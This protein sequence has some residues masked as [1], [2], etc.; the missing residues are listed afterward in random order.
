MVAPFDN[1]SGDP[2][3]DYFVDGMRDAL[4][5]ELTKVA[6]LTVITGVAERIPAGE[7]PDA[8]I[9]A[10]SVL[11]IG[12]RVRINARL[13]EGSTNR[14]VWAESYDGDLRD[15][16]ALHGRVA[17]AITQ[18]VEAELTPQEETRLATAPP[19]DPEAYNLYLR[20][21]FHW[22]KRTAAGL[23]RAVRYF[24]QAIDVDP[25][26]ALAYAGLADAYVLFPLYRVPGVSRGE[27]YQLAEQSAREALARDSTLG[28]AR[29]ALAAVLFQAHRDWSR[30]ALEFQRALALSPGY[31]TLHQWYSEYLRAAGRVEES[32]AEARRAYRL[33]PLEPVISTSLASGLWVA[34]R[35]DEAIAEARRTL[36]ELDPSYADAYNV[37]ALCYLALSRFD[38]LATTALQAGYP[39]SLVTPVTQALTGAGSREGAV[40]AITMH[41]SLLDPFQAAVL[42]SAV[43]EK[44]LALESLERAEQEGNVN[45]LIYLKSAPAFEE[46]RG[47]ARYHALLQKL[48]VPDA[49]SADR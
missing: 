25:G 48:G 36:D 42:Y 47:E 7:T 45:L 1:L 5:T 22:N 40:R 37:L 46:L 28:E 43:G 38:E 6:D 29:T 8:M 3:Q 16:L 21:R 2:G 39:S 20:G 44:D 10:G 19:V 18:Q 12:H 26:D 41:E 31:A 23:Q 9:L 13:V 14:N 33:D 49:P 34:G 4:I 15:V 35:Y 27:A 30:A 24:Q 11:P 32:L 17:R